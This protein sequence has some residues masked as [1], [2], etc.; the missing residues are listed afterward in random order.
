MVVRGHL[1]PLFGKLPLPK[2]TK[3][4][5]RDQLRTKRVSNKTLANVQ[6]VL[7]K[8]L[9]DEVDEYEL[10]KSNLILPLFYRTQ[11]IAYFSPI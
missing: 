3:K 11:P 10:I 5:V 9:T 2:L 6:N 1:A 8:A 7:R 4:A